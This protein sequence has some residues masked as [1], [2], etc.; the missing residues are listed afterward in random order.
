MPILTPM[1]CR[2]IGLLQIIIRLAYLVVTRQVLYMKRYKKH[3]W[4][5]TA[6]AQ[7]VTLTFKQPRPFLN[8]ETAT[9]TIWYRNLTYQGTGTPYLNIRGLDEGS[10]TFY[11]QAAVNLV[12]NDP[13]WRKAVVSTTFTNIN[14]SKAS[15]RIQH[16][17]S[18]IG[19]YFEIE[20][21]AA[22]FE[23]GAFATSYIP[24]TTA[25]VIRNA[26]VVTVSTT[27]WNAAEGTFF[28]VCSTPLNPY[29]SSV[30]QWSG[31]SNPT[32]RVGGGTYRDTKTS[33]DGANYAIS[34][35]TSNSD[36]VV[37]T[38]WNSTTGVLGAYYNGISSYY[39]GPPFNPTP[40]ALAY[41]GSY[42]INTFVYDGPISRVL[43]YHSALSESD[44][45][46]ITN[47]IKDGP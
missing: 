33:Q 12:P 41:I 37:A 14:Q 8:G 39:N 45:V 17:Q 46:S 16:T 26:D 28:G 21:A 3:E 13:N 42:H 36:R 2:I 23:K 43:L 4:N 20:L 40:S 18:N 22:Q 6:A 25:A 19:D 34:P 38:T 29:N 31:V 30:V 35:A 11:N 5:I 47:S 32:L 9:A 15:F 7:Q 10:T 24:T 27:N 1:E 44:I